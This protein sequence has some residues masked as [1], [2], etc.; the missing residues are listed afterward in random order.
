MRDV[1]EVQG[2][3]KSYGRTK[4]VS[5]VTF[6]VPRGA[7]YGFLG[8]N[9]AGKTTTIRLLMQLLQPDG[10]RLMLFGIPLAKRSP[11][12]LD[13]V[14]Y[15]PGDFRPHPEM[16]AR[17]FL[18]YMARFRKRP[19]RLRAELCER[20]GF[21]EREQRQVI[22]HLSHGNRQKLGLLLALEHEPELAILD[23]PTLGLDPL[24]QDAFNEIVREM[25][26]RGATVFLSS[27]ILADI[28][29]VCSAVA[30]IRAGQI[31]AEETIEA[32]KRRRPRRLVVVPNGASMDP[33]TFPGARLHARA[34]NRYTYWI[35]G[36]VREVMKAVTRAAVQEFYLPEPDLED[37]FMSYYQQGGFG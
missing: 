10:G 5:D 25:Q 3:S 35:D 18:E 13:R 1:I 29:K 32:L 9:G 37:V 6:S 4:G 11:R 8:P 2:L 23:E 14:G 15:L 26:G 12:L 27:H 34:P 17:R 19:P 36:D 24:V 31:V 28:E 21:G 30:I 20:L 33:P 16:R 7:V 22:K